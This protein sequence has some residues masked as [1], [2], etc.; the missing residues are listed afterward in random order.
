[1]ISWTVSQWIPS[2]SQAW[3][4]LPLAR[5][6]STAKRSNKSV[7]RPWGAAQGTA[8]V[9]TPCSGQSERGARARIK[10]VNCIVSRCRQVRSGAQS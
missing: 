2:N 9:L 1:M 3:L 5:S 8:I 6:T 7:K 4:M 10:V